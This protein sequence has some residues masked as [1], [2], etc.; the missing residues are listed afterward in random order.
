MS[1]MF[2]VLNSKGKS[3]LVKTDAKKKNTGNNSD[4]YGINNPSKISYAMNDTF[5]NFYSKK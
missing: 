5:F 1:L 4:D 2:F 3:V